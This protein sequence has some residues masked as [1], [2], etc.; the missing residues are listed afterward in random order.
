MKRGS[1]L[2]P[3]ASKHFFTKLSFP[4]KWI[5]GKDSHQHLKF[6]WWPSQLEMSLI[7][8]FYQPNNNVTWYL[9]SLPKG[10]LIVPSP[11]VFPRS[12]HKTERW[13]IEGQIAHMENQITVEGKFVYSW[14][15]FY[16]SAGFTHWRNENVHINYSNN[17]WIIPFP[18]FSFIRAS[19][20]IKAPY[21]TKKNTSRQHG[22]LKIKRF[23]Q[24]S[25]L[26]IQ[27]ILLR[28]D[29]KWFW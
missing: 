7:C 2:E 19:V 4:S 6:I 21:E 11:Y 12:L 28:N 9:L 16:Q 17:G 24:Q 20:F 14:M 5:Q 18:P 22:N 27:N 25:Y 26:S 10:W 23:L 1:N 29:W 13:P 8:Q 3:R 15:V